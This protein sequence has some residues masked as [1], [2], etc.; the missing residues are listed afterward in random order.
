[1]GRSDSR[2]QDMTDPSDATR[3]LVLEP[4]DSPDHLMAP[5]FEKAR[6]ERR[7]HYASRR[8]GKRPLKRALITMVHNEPVFLPIWLGYYSR[9]FDPRDIYVLDNETTDGSTSR[10]GF[11]RI[12]VAQD[13]VN[14]TWMVRTIEELQHD[15]L[16][17]YDVV[18]V[19]DVDEIIA[20][21]PALGS[22]G[23]YLDRFDEEWVNC[24]GYELLHLRNSEP[25]LALDR[26]ILH[27]RRCWYFNGAYDKAAL[28]TVP[29]QWRPGFH[30]RT[31]F[32]FNPDPDLRLIHLHRMDF[33][34]CRE[35]HRTR[36]RR[37]W[38]PADAREGWATHNQIADGE[39]FEKWFYEDSGFEGFEMRRE[40]IQPIWRDVV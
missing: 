13:R 12:P 38:A 27:Q 10:D 39:A 1:M 28:A 32:N 8:P 36:S 26:P 34:I 18:V 21:T 37:L 2:S 25:P 17:R 30:G 3:E 9:F 11:V 20:P 16:G 14:H 7:E 33:D 22:L 29:M 23:K 35:R 4:W 15:L 5:W 24:L 31:D 6:R 40:D 19:T